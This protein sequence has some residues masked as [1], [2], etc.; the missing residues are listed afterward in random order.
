MI[1]KEPLISIII[2]NYNAGSLL[3][4]CVESIFNS[5]YKNLEVIVVDNVSKDNSHKI[6][7]EKFANII[8][9]ENKENLGYCGGN[10]VGIEHANGEFLVILN[11]DVIVD[12]DWLNQLLSA[13]RKYGDG[14]YQPK[15]LAT[16]DHSTI[17]SAGNMIQLFGFGF[18]R[19]KG[20]KDI[21]QYEKDEEVGYASGTCLFSS[22]EIFRKIGNF[23][24]YLFAY[25]DDL[26]LCWRGRLKGIKSFYVHN[27]IIYH[28]LEGY[29]FK[30]NSFKFFLMERNRLYCLQKNFSRKTILKMLPSLILVDIAVTLFYLKKGFV[31]AKIKANLDIL[32]NLSTISKN[33]NLIQKNR[34]VSDD[35]LIKKFT[36]K[37]EVPQW[38]I[39]KENNNF[40]NKI[41][42]KL[43]WFSRL[44]FK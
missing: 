16:T 6:C 33:H 17:I 39:E 5:N 4:E 1:E 20:E 35:E 15:I 3:L 21:G 38:V 42:E 40:L 32:R 10:N 30:W 9:I 43:S 26:D 8:L 31:S 29:S 14:L 36:N 23:D 44:W 24:S 19:G 13:F 7:K 37:M 41:F 25:H 28:P 11:P 18:S 12:P 2:L 34:T 27:S 22:L